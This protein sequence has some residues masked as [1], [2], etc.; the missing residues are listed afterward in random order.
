MNLQKILE[1]RPFGHPLHPLLTH[2]PLGM[3]L[4][5]LIFDI[6]GFA[7]GATWAFEA[8]A[9]SMF[10]GTALALPTAITGLN[11]WLDI[12]ADHPAQN[13]ALWHMGLMIPSTAIFIL[14]TVLHFVGRDTQV[15]TV[16]LGLTIV[17][18]LLTIVGGYLGGILI[19]DDGISVGRHRRNTDLP[20]DTLHE[21]RKGTTELPLAPSQGLGAEF[22]PVVP[23]AAL[24]EGKTMRVEMQGAVM[25]LV[26]AGGQIFA[27]QEYC[28]HRCGPL[29]EGETRFDGH[30][31]EIR[32]PWHGSCFDL[33]TGKV[34]HGPAKVDLKTYQVAIRHGIV[35]VRLEPAPPVTP[36][37]ATERRNPPEEP[38]RPSTTPRREEPSRRPQT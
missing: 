22:H 24:E 9:W 12:R 23:E 6:T 14:D 8:A 29:S 17:G 7:S 37:T 27:V 31:R 33:A 32:C 26:R 36:E 38:R 34:T 28:T 19:Y 4:F 16:M 10:L 35:H 18:Y 30:G 11:D 20:H 15:T 5:A 2:L 25:T 13:T 1:G 3:W 21:P